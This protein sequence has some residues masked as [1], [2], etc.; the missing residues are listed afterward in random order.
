M[1]N[2]EIELIFE[3]N[4]DNNLQNPK[5]KG[6]GRPKKYSSLEEANEIRKK[7]SLLYYRNNRNPELIEREQVYQDFK[8]G[9]LIYMDNKAKE[10]LMTKITNAL[11]IAIQ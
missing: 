4:P 7:Q 8:S 1:S 10:L 9:K 2:V 6:R 5:R 11:A 3:E